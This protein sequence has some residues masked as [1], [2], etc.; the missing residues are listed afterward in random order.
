MKI[1]P[2]WAEFFHADGRTDRDRYDEVNSFRSFANM[3]K[4]VCDK[5]TRT[6]TFWFQRNP[7][8]AEKCNE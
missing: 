7:Y 1:C 8:D 5:N 2:V 6:P 3:P 4:I